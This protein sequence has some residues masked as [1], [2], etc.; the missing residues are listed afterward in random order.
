MLWLFFIIIVLINGYLLTSIIFPEFP[1]YFKFAA[2]FSFGSF[3]SISILYIFVSYIFRDL[4]RGLSLFVLVS[5]VFW[6]PARKY[7]LLLKELL[8]LSK[9]QIFFLICVFFFSSYIFGKSFGYDSRHGQFLIASNVY[10]DF[11]I[12]IPFIRSFSLG[13]NFPAEVPGFA[14][15]KLPYHFLP[16]FYAGVL[17][18]LGLRIDFAFNLISTLACSS[19]FIFIYSF[20]FF[21]FRSQA[22]SLLS[23]LLFGCTNNFALFDFLKNKKFSFSLFSSFWHNTTYFSAGPL[24]PNTMLVYWTM[25]TYLNQRQLIFGMTAIFLL[26][27]FLFQKQEKSNALSILLVGLLAGSMPFWNTPLFL[28]EMI[29]MSLYIVMYGKMWR[30][31]IPVFIIMLFVAFPSTFL[32]SHSSEN[33]VVINP[34]FVLAGNVT[35]MRF[36]LFWQWNLGVLLWLFLI[37]FFISDQ[38]RKKFFI[39]ISGLFLVVNVFQFSTALDSSHKLINLWLIFANMYA[40]Y[41]LIKVFTKGKFG[42]VLSGSMLFFLFLSGVLNFLV[43]KNDVY[44]RM[45]DYPSNSLMRWSLTHLP[46]DKVI[47]TNGEIYDPL[48]LVGKK[49]FLGRMS[50]IITYGGGITKRAE[51]EDTLLTG[52]DKKEK[53]TILK[54]NNIQYVVLYKDNFF[55]NTKFAN[56]NFYDQNYKKIYEDTFGV[57][58]KI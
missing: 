38:K 22:V 55:K 12:H 23:L 47:V 44:A 10:S 26:L 8:K 9:K 16:D 25:D 46:S 43:L 41:A 17:E 5:I 4:H 51:A 42:K 21:L 56:R 39:F 35:L 2:I 18:Y 40:S 31:S 37:G 34:G 6:I 1:S 33:H 14:G 29:I 45:Y 48:S 11:G 52:K 20:S 49:I 54:T 3:F 57:V 27:S 7:F 28:A 30:K 15:E 24:G 58:Y 50:Y 19:L 36:F 13:N 53:Q 32:I